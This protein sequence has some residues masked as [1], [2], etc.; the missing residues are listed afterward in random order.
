MSTSD[1]AV[2]EAWSTAAFDLEPVATRTG[3]FVRRDVLKV[4]H[5]HRGASGKLLIVEG[6]DA[7]LPLYAEAGTV[8]FVGEADL[9]DYHSPLG[10][11]A[12][13][14]SLASAFFADLSPGTADQAG[15]PA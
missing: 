3:P 15:Q 1:L 13:V 4:W 11:P 14:R 5:R 12:A 6:P 2:H 7:L 10:N 8:G 9:T